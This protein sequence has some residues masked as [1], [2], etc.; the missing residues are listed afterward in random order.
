MGG[1]S[2][3]LF[4]VF[5]LSLFGADCGNDDLLFALFVGLLIL[6]SDWMEFA[7][8]SLLLV[9]SFVGGIDVLDST[10]FF[11]N[12]EFFVSVFSQRLAFNLDVLYLPI[13]SW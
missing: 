2:L 6:P 3:V 1:L 12:F 11:L 4:I 10:C 5:V 7:V 13:Y 9:S 8:L